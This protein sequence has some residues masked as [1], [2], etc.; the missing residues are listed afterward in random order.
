MDWALLPLKRYADFRGR[1][2]RKEFWSYQLLIFVAMILLTIVDG[3][4]GLG[5]SLTSYRMMGPGYYWSGGA[6][7]GGLLTKIFS[8]AILIPS[9]AVGVRRLHDA[10][11]T[12]WWM[13][14]VFVP[15]VGWLILL[16]FF[17]LEG[18]RG[19]NRYGPDPTGE[20]P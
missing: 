16:V 17:I 15:F 12:G 9:L 8:L 2:R 4:S 1:S 5:G 13:L 7:N 20:L 3:T 10:D 6:M 14:L 19:P 18:R 11:R